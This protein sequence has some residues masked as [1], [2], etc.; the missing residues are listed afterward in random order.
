MRRDEVSYLVMRFIGVRGEVWGD[1]QYVAEYVGELFAGSHMGGVEAETA[2]GVDI[3]LGVIE[4]EGLLGLDATVGAGV[5]K[6]GAVGLVTL[7]LVACDNAV[8]IVCH[9]PA[10]LT[11]LLGYV[12]V[13]H[14]RVGIGEQ[15][16]L[17]AAAQF[18]Q[19]LEAA[20][21]DA[22]E[23]E[24][25]GTVDFVVGHRAVKEGSHLAV[26]LVGSDFALFER[27]EGT[28][29]AIFAEHLGGIGHA[30]CL[31][32]THAAHAV[33][34]HYHAAQVEEQIFYHSHYLIIRISAKLQQIFQ[35]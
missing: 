34:I 4:K 10:L 27:E 11:E 12:A 3:G 33:K 28:F 20:D 25:K 19:G 9:L 26:K 15:I 30:E 5:V 14:D 21:R 23:K 22:G 31:E 7:G 6:D 29:L 8:E 17:V 18:A 13:H 35:L 1:L 16:H 24:V 32:G 2:R